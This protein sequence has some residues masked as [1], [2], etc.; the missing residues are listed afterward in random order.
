MK[1]ATI[2]FSILL[3]AIIIFSGCAQSFVSQVSSS[4][5]NSTTSSAKKIDYEAPLKILVPYTPF[6]VK[7]DHAVTV[8]KEGT[9]F[10]NMEFDLFPEQNY[11][12]KL[13]LMFSSGDV[14][15]DYVMIGAG[16][17]EK[18]MYA[19]LVQ[20][21]LLTDLTD[22]LPSFP[23]LSAADPIGFEALAV[24]GKQFALAWTGLSY[25]SAQYVIRQDWLDAL[26]LE[27]PGT[28]DELYDV[29]KAFKEEDPGG[30]GAENIPFCINPSVLHTSISG[31]YGIIYPFEDRDGKLV[32]TRLTPEYKEYLAFMSQLYSEGILD[33]DYPINTFSIVTEKGAAGRVGFTDGSTEGANQLFLAREKEGLEPAVCTV[34]IP[35]MNPDNMRICGSTKGL[36]RICM[37]PKS[38]KYA[39]EVLAMVDAFLE[40]AAMESMIHGVE[41][42]D[43]TVE[44]DV[45]MPILPNFDENRGNLYSIL[46]LQDGDAY[47]PLWTMRTRKNAQSIEY[48]GQ[49]LAKTLDYQTIDPLAFAPA[50]ESISNMTKNVN[51]YALQEATKFIAGARKLDEFDSFVSEMKVKGADEIVETYNEW[52]TNK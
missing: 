21:D 12:D 11:L 33:P 49:I 23:N 29:L 40:P 16:G 6:D 52:Y 20:K 3:S 30:L 13:S 45:R 27:A 9:G 1:K 14:G 19:T 47:F 7:T 36:Q 42:E 8:L 43:Y 2:L 18:G 32:D 22:L 31:T 48:W 4:Q 35:L 41:G 51:E 24:D 38:S 28:R 25:P 15:Y 10:V 5:A 50:F 46:P 44:N 26:N 17:P 34:M 39:D 37:I